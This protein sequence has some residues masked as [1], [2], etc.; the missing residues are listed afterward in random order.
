LSDKCFSTKR[1]GTL[2]CYQ[3]GKSGDNLQGTPTEGE[4]SVQFSTTD[5]LIK[6]GCFVK[7]KAIVSV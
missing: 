6:V 3:C 4:G 5:L 7:M 1:R 2:I